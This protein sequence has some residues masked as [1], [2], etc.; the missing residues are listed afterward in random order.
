MK[1]DN[2]KAIQEHEEDRTEKI[3]TI[4]EAWHCGQLLLSYRRTRQNRT[5]GRQGEDIGFWC[6]FSGVVFLVP[7]CF[8]VH[9]HMLP[10][11]HAEA[12]TCTAFFALAWGRCEAHAHASTPGGQ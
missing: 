9:A 1:K 10:C 8:L 3:L 5:T 7:H 11:L 6:C 2:K 12:A 4:E